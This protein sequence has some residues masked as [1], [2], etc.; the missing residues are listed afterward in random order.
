MFREIIVGI[1]ADGDGLDQVALAKN[2]LEDGG[3][4]TLAHVLTS[5]SCAGRGT[6]T[7]LNQREVVARRLE[8]IRA[9]ARVEGKVRCLRSSSA[10][11]GLRQLARELRADLLVIGQPAPREAD[12][13]DALGPLNG[14]PCAV[15]VARTGGRSWIGAVGVGYD[16]SAESVHALDVARMIA[17]AH[18]AAVSA[19]ETVSDPTHAVGSR[20]S[21]PDGWGEAQL[22]QARR[23]LD[24]LD[25]VTGQAVYGRPSDQLAA[26]SANVDLMV[27]G[28]RSSGPAGRF[29]QGTTSS[30][31]ALR[32]KCPLL[33]LPRP[34]V[35]AERA[36]AR[37][38]SAA[39]AWA[40]APV[41][42]PAIDGR[43]AP[44]SFDLAAELA[45]WIG[46]APPEVTVTEPL[47]FP[48]PVPVRHAPYRGGQML[49]AGLLAWACVAA[50][51]RFGAR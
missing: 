8:S 31:L 38:R 45:A 51:R 13:H 7:A 26:Y 1:D 21:M 32:A 14:A 24:A 30:R 15:A 37:S 28:S 17:G 29:V 18:D 10:G 34:G 36:A 41:L 23:R 22:D 16:G 35:D 46:P 11:H 20:K 3:R 6:G 47:D 40:G 9:Q 42:L 5:D 39:L 49:A 43:A 50:T 44:E 12:A 33:I 19:C 4:L 25:G 48:P 27:V 2:L